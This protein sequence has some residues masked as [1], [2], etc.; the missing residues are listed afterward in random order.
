MN[1][2]RLEG[3][4]CVVTGAKTGI[5][6]AISSV[7]AAE[8]ATLIMVNKTSAGGEEFARELG[9]NV[10]FKVCDVSNEDSVK[11]FMTWVEE[12]FGRIDVLVNN[13]A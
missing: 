10:Y 11:A 4:I 6:R 13:A 3:K 2:N 9:P 1:Y 12:R 5:G 7:F 8:K